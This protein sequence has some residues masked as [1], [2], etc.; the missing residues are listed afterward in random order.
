MRETTTLPEM[1]ELADQ[2]GEFIHY[3]GF[4]R[5]HGKIWTHLFLAEK[6]LDAADLVRDMKISK[7]LVSISMRELMEYEVVIDAGKSERGTHLYR[8]NPDILAVILNVL[9]QREKRMLSRIIAA[10]ESLNAVSPEDKTNTQL[11]SQRINQLGALVQNAAMS[12]ESLIALRSVD[13]GEWRNAFIAGDDVAAVTPTIQSP[14]LTQMSTKT[15]TQ[16]PVA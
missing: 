10:Q 3:W 4:K 6:P 13:F 2:I 11:S 7:A 9:R 15:N 12:L 16:A 1:Q 8:T 14:C 5:I